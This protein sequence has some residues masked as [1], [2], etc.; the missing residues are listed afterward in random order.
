MI[1][2]SSFLGKLRMKPFVNLCLYTALQNR[3]SISSNFLVFHT[4]RGISSRPAAFLF[5]IFPSNSLNYS[6]VNCPS[7]T[8]SW[9]LII[10][11]I[12]F[13]SDFGEFSKKILKCSFHVCICSW[14]AAFSF[15]LSFHLLSST[16]F[17]I[18]YLLPSFLFYWS[19]LECI[20]FVL[21][22]MY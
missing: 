5:L 4:S 9:L 12:R 22:S 20:F 8:S 15:F 2:S 14:L 19:D 21:F 3:G 6:W 17:V 16:L 7:L 10:F 18:V 13:I 11:V 1:P